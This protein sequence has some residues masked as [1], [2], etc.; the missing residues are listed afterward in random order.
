[1]EFRPH[2]DDP[3]PAHVDLFMGTMELRLEHLAVPL[4]FASRK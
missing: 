4:E 2:G 1:M 3:G